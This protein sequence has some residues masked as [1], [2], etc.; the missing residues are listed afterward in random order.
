MIQSLGIRNIGVI[1]SAE[2]ELG[3]GLIALTGETGAGKTMVLTA[4]GLLMGERA[5]ASRVR[6]GERQLFVEGRLTTE[7]QD[8]IGRIEAIGG[9]VDGSEI[10]INRSVTEDGRSRAAVCGASVPVSQLSE[11]A[12]EVITIHGQSDQL[13]LR[14][15]A[16]QR[17][18]LDSF[19][20]E[21]ESAK[22]SYQQIYSQYRELEARI[23][24]MRT[25]S[26]SDQ[27]RLAL[28][29]T[30]ISAIEKLD[31]KA[32]ELAELEERIQ[33]L[34]NVEGLRE[35]AARAY[36]SLIGEDEPA[37][38]E[39][40]ALARRALDGQAD[41][42]L[43]GLALRLGEISG[44]LSEV[45]VELAGYLSDLEADPQLLDS[46]MSRKAELV[47]LERMFGLD[48]DSVIELL[49][50]L[51]A[52]VLDLDSSDEQLERLEV[53]LEAMLSQ[54]A[55]AAAALSAARRAAAEQVSFA[56]TSEL[57]QLAMS[58]ATFVVQVSE[59]SDFEL[60]GNDRVEFL[61]SAH[62]GAEPRP[63]SKG[64]SGG[65][66]SRIMLAI[67]LVLAGQRPMPTMIFDEVD[68][69]VGGQAALELAKRL[70]QLS[71]ST[72]VIV[73]THLAQVAAFADQQIRV[74]KDS[75]GNITQTS[76]QELSGA[77]RQTEIARMLSGNPDSESALSHALELL[78]LAN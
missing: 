49:P 63:I 15:S 56:V 67:E 13:R 50:R 45:S 47:Q 2:L 18:A 64:A 46:L 9:D 61:L 55:A 4:L 32:Q 28:L 23:D 77:E 10:I 70:K 51:H 11:L 31:P 1:S 54:V 39:L 59:L 66:L 62:P 20:R 58:G 40:V 19:S 42:L 17:E 34:S 53:Q 24:R 37:A 36:G 5:D 35:S 65:E 25:S 73:V 68:A 27:Q 41:P 26:E 8:L 44:Q 78:Q 16:N 48:I 33:R 38:G 71:R 6:T 43:Q 30:E 12:S 74:A 52:E 7:N 60:S 57:A 29:K 69:G 76:V 3:S 21:I 72:Q 14:S 22:A 75:S